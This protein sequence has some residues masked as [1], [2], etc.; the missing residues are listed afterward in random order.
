M[1]WSLAE[2]RTWAKAR[3]RLTPATERRWVLLEVRY[4]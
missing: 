4:S 3:D 2:R 1:K